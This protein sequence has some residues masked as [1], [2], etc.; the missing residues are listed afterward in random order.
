[1]GQVQKKIGCHKF[2]IIIENINSDIKECRIGFFSAKNTKIIKLMKN[3]EAINILKEEVYDLFSLAETNNM[4][5]TNNAV[6]Q[7]LKIRKVV[8]I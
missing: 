6:N 3:V 2:I 5:L 8:N 7:T 1:M 4:H